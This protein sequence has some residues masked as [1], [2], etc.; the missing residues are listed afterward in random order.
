MDVVKREDDKYDII[1]NG[2]EVAA[3]PFVSEDAAWSWADR[4]IDDQTFDSPN[5]LADPI[6]YREDKQ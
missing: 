3:G 1:H 5:T 6:K 4:N 2:K